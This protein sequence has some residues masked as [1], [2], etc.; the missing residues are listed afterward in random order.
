MPTRMRVLAVLLGSFVLLSLAVGDEKDELAN[1]KVKTTP[2]GGGAYEL[3]GAGGNIAVLVGDDGMFVID[4][5]IIEVSP[6]I[7]AALAALSKKP[8]RFVLNT[9]WHPDHSGGNLALAGTG[10]VIVAHE[11]VRQRLSTKQ[12]VSLFN[13]EVPPSPAAALP[14]VTFAD[15]IAFHV[16]GEEIRVIHPAPAHTDGDA[17]VFL[18]KANVVHMGDTYMT[19]SYPFVDQSSGGR[20]DGFIDA[21]NRA[22]ALCDDKT[23]VIPGHGPLADKAKLT[24]W[25]DMLVAIRDRVK[26]AADAGKTLEQIQAAKLTAEWD[27]AW[28]AEFIK[29]EQVV[30]F[31]Y[32][33]L[34]KG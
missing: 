32:D 34:K 15:G 21:A 16:N 22:L 25:R 11:N 27:A 4:D 1:L 33:S 23:K 2:L 31:A 6:K 3:E 30:K 14:L 9:H 29:S 19:V 10:A 28:G 26:K 24:A 17:I 5:D 18:K 8:V 20:F 13:K 7:Q 12:F